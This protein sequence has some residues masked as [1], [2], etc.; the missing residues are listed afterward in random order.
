[1]M[2]TPRRALALATA[3]A[4]ALAA[5]GEAPDEEPTDEVEETEDAEVD[6]EPDEDADDA[7]A[8][9]PDADDADDEADDEV[10]AD[11]EDFQACQITDTGGVD[12]RSFN[13]TVWE[14]FQQAEEELGIEIAVLES[15]SEADF[16]PN[17]R[18]FIDRGCDLIV[19]VGFLLGEATEQAA[20][21]NPEQLF[22]IVDFAFEDT[23]D[24]VREIVFETDEAGFLAGYVSAGTTETG[25]I[26]TYGGINIPT[27]SIFMDG[28]LAGAEYY[29]DE[30]GTDVAVEGWDGNDGLFTGD[31]ESQDEGRRVT[32]SLLEGGADIIMP[33]AG[34]VGLGSATAIEDFGEGLLI[35]VDTDGYVSAPEFSDLMLTSV[36]KRMDVASFTVIEEVMNDEFEGGI[37]AGDLENEGVGIADFH[38]HEDTV[39][40]EVKDALD[41]L[42]QGIIDGEISVDPADY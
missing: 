17:I 12:D 2:T 39:P 37:F 13:Q 15:E 35:W 8:E 5:C 36:L 18:A 28:Y 31:F 19:T 9:D 40:D 10:A 38:D 26:G 11:A 3:G 6:D 30:H 41:D 1:M 32:D 29:N 4:L 23:Y 27:V 20:Q 24:N 14:G 33:V 7:D 21:E 34:P 22:A 42:E 25:T 16:D